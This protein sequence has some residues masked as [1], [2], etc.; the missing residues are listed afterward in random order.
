MA[1][2]ILA[3]TDLFAGKNIKIQRAYFGY[4]YPYFFVVL[5]LFCAV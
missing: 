4:F 1:E 3:I 2:A 5:T